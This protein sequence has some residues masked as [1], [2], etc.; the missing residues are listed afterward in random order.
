[1]D[2]MHRYGVVPEA[3][4]PLDGGRCNPFE[5]PEFLSHG[6]RS[7]LD[8]RI[9]H[10]QANAS[11]GIRENLGAWSFGFT[12]DEMTAISGRGMRCS[13]SRARHLRPSFARMAPGSK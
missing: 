11:G 6:S 5:E 3:W 7:R 4:V 13:G 9:G 1:M 2:V 12:P 10:P 8:G